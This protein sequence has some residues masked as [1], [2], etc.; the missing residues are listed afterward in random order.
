M[1]ETKDIAVTFIYCSSTE[2]NV[3]IEDFLGSLLRQFLR[4]QSSLPVEIK[5]VYKRHVKDG[6]R[7]SVHEYSELL[8][9]QA[10]AFSNI[11]IILDAL[12]ECLEERGLRDHLLSELQKFPSQLLITSRPHISDITRHFGTLNRLEIRASETDIT[13]YLRMRI[14]KEQRL[15]QLIKTNSELPEL[16]VQTI[17]Q[18]VDGMLDP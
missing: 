5:S 17:V 7:P 18:N 2:S 6:T 10:R 11:F 15:Q 1:I 4:Q 9:S 8:Q 3:H 12:D 14:D 16:I 13:Q